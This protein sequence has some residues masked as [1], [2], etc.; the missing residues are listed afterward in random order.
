[1]IL[2]CLILLRISM[3]KVSTWYLDPKDD[4]IRYCGKNDWGERIDYFFLPNEPY[5]FDTPGEV[6]MW[7]YDTLEHRSL[8][9]AKNEEH[10][11][12]IM[13]AD[14]DEQNRDRGA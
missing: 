5:K 3:S 10:A 6:S 11:V 2:P 14:L 1:M 4:G 9:P 8:G 7:N 12:E 13:Q